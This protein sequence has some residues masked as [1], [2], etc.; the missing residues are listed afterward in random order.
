M[1]LQCGILDGEPEVTELLA[2]DLIGGTSPPLRNNGRWK[3]DRDQGSSEYSGIRKVGEVSGKVAI[4]DGLI[5]QP[6]G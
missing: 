4:H 2:S 3:A 5:M 6:I 1:T